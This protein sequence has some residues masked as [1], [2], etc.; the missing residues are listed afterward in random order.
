VKDGSVKIIKKW[1]GKVA[2]INAVAVLACHAS[3]A[4]STK[5]I[6]LIPRKSELPHSKNF[7]KKKR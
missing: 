7:R 3:V 1:R 2:I 6:G 5:V 4:P